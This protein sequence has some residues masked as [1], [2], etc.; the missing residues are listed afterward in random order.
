MAENKGTGGEQRQASQ[1]VIVTLRSDD[2]A[3]IDDVA[4][5]LQAAGLIIDNVL[6]TLGQVTGRAEPEGVAR[7]QDIEQVESVSPQRTMG[8]APPD[9]DIQ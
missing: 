9:A 1:T 3:Q 7:L 6:R 2:L 5:K 4:Q 8:V